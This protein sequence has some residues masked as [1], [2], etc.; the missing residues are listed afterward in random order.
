MHGNAT[1]IIFIVHLIIL[2]WNVILTAQDKDS[3]CFIRHN[4]VG[5]L[6]NDQKIAIVGS[7]KNLE[8]KSFYLVDAD[9]PD[10][11]VYKR[12]ISA[13][14][15]NKNTPFR[16]NF[17]CDFSNFSIEGR[18][19]I[20][21]EDGALSHQFV[22]GG[23]KEY[24]D[25]LALVLE[26]FHAQRCGDID[27]ILHK[28]CHLN[29]RK[30]S[31]DVSGGW[32]DAGDYIK[33]MITV[34][35]AAIELV[36][37]VDYAISYNFENALSDNFPKNDNPDLLD[38]ARI[39]L[40]WVLK[41]TA[42]Y[43]DENYFYQVSGEEDH[44]GWR[45]PEVDDSTRDFG[46]SRSLHK[47]WGG[48]LLGRSSA[49][50]AIAYRVYQKY[51]KKFADE[52]LKRAESLFAD[53]SKYEKVQKSIPPDFYNET[54][55]LDDMVLGAAELYQTTKKIEY[56]NYAKINLPKLTGDD[57]GWNGTDYL[58]Y[59]ACLKS[60]IEPSYC[61]NKMKAILESKQEQ[62]K[63]E[64]YYLSSGYVWGTTAL[65]TS[66]AQKAIMYYY[67]TSDTSYLNLAAAQR[68]YLLGRNNWGVS[69]VI[70]LGSVYPV[71]SHSQ[72]DS[73]AGLHRGAIVGGPAEKTSWLRTFPNLRIN[74]DKFSKF[75]TDI[76]YYDNRQ[77]YYCN[78]VALDYTAPTVFLF[79]HNIAIS[80]NDKVSNK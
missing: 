19:K 65:F 5:Y 56:L 42:E 46:K 62:S 73:L 41:M 48:N 51:D 22:I 52:C 31:I 9:T 37:A 4:M 32:H 79:L 28:P 47:G 12:I 75:Q 13:D 1:I 54:E 26:F 25:A 30:A 57:I 45:L 68:D 72:L 40:E 39:G 7:Q 67:L 2:K 63:N 43:A 50:L 60:K 10:K 77:D 14:R 27:P 24:Q 33:Y 69:F 71:N 29:D 34:T 44:H 17:P 16:Y 61:Q 15:G 49:A 23:L 3:T 64:V 6:V 58:A 18:Y 66:D 11:V 8:G 78:E 74:H 59:A 76:I 36:T 38:E 70:G 21:L 35:F 80:L 55:W 20:K 53:R